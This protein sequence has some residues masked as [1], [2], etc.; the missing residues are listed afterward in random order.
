MCILLLLEWI[1]CCLFYCLVGCKNGSHS[2][3]LTT[4]TALTD[5]LKPPTP[6]QG[7][8]PTSRMPGVNV[9]KVSLGSKTG[10]KSTVLPTTI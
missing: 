7:Y 8:H 3:N 2:Q 5:D 10:T 4:S 9:G 1:Y 6:R